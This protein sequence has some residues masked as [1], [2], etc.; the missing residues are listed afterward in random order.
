MSRR[1][2]TLLRAVALA[3]GVAVLSPVDPLVLACVP[4]AVLLLAFHGRSWL[5]VGLAGVLLGFSFAGAGSATPL[6]FAERGWALLLGGG[7]VL[8]TLLLP[9]RGAMTRSIGALGVAFGAVGILAALRPAALAEVDWWVGSR[10][11]SGAH[12]AYDLLGTAALDGGVGEAIREVARVQTVLYPALLGLAS[13]G[14]LGVGWYVAG[15]LRGSADA[16]RPLREFRFSDHLV[17]VLIGGLALF[18]LPVGGVAARLGENAVAFM[19]GLYLLRG[20]AVLVW[21]AAALLTSTWSAVLWGAVAVLCYP[22]VAGAALVIGLGDTWL[23]LRRR[24]HPSPGPGKG[25]G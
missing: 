20:V 1:G 25:R 17:W 10:L 16:L 9:A 6:W 2:W 3:L 21:L 24:L 8:W 15:R 13:L 19:G 23:D 22:V 11:T 7:F 4:I 14:A 12:T 18:L 5:A